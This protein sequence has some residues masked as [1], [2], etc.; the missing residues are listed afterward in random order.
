LNIRSVMVALLLVASCLPLSMNGQD[1][2]LSPEGRKLRDA[3][4][5]LQKKP[6]DPTVQEQYL[7]AFP[8][9]Y[10]SFLR[11]FDYPNGELYDGSEFILDVWSSLAKNHE[12]EVGRLLVQ[13]SKDARYDADAPNYLKHET[14]IYGGQHTKTFAALLQ[15]LAPAER[16]KLI[17]FLADAENFAAWPEFQRLVD[18]LNS[19]GQEGLAQQFEAARTAREKRKH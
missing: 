13:L 8:Q 3:L 16:A 9:D 6:N 11:L 2:T 7:Q 12:T 19:V 1:K 4:S 15:Q 14:V 18:S 17:T 5:E 10:K